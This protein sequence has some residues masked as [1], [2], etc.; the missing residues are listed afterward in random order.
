MSKGLRLLK[1]RTLSEDS[2]KKGDHKSLCSGLDR[3][4]KS[5][6]LNN[7]LVGNAIINVRAIGGS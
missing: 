5:E 4:Y 1:K 7:V 2:H 3:V 6:T